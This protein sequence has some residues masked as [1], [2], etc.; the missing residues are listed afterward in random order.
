MAFKIDT[1]HVPDFT[2]NLG[3]GNTE[4][5]PQVAWNN[6][7]TDVAAHKLSGYGFVVIERGVAGYA[8]FILEEVH[9]VV[10]TMLVRGPNPPP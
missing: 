1:K 6:I 10:G 2:L 5:M 8:N 3:A 9:G 7:S 4:H